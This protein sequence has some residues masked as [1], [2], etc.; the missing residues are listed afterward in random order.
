MRS[1]VS[2]QYTLC[3]KRGGV[4]RQFQ[5][6]GLSFESDSWVCGVNY[7]WGLSVIRPFQALKRYV[8]HVHDSGVEIV[9]WWGF[10]FAAEL[11]V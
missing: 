11:G 1:A 10:L 3:S 9:F 2:F 4:I 6:Q 8:S 5:P 7:I